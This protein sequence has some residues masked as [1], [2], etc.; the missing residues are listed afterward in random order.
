MPLP[1]RIAA[2]CHACYPQ[3]SRRSKE[4]AMKT[5]RRDFVKLTGCLTIGF[6]L[7]NPSGSAAYPFA[8]EIP[9]SLKRNPNINS[10]IEVLANGNVRVFTGKLELG[11]GIR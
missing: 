1:V 8:T 3:S 2:T 6:V 9:E 10:W 7:G 11:Q 4:F 5:S